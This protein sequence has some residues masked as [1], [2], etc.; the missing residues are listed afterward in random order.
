MKHP[1][2]SLPWDIHK[3]VSDSPNGL[4][5]FFCCNLPQFLTNVLYDAKDS[6][7]HIHRLLLPDCLIDL[8]FREHSPWLTGKINKCLKFISLCKRKCVPLV[9]NLM[10]DRINTKTG[11][12][13]NLI[14]PYHW[15]LCIEFCQK[16]L[17]HLSSRIR[18]AKDDFNFLHL[19][20]AFKQLQI[21]DILFQLSS[22]IHH[23]QLIY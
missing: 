14:P 4:N 19:S 7:A 17:C 8:L 20:P 18:G 15:F 10:L 2:D 1:R 5:I 3:F 21:N 9:R 22:Y 23:L 16:L 13:K 6:T 12:L 11:I